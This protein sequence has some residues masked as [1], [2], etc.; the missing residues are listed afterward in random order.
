MEKKDLDQEVDYKEI[1]SKILTKDEFEKVNLIMNKKNKKKWPNPDK[2]LKR[3][4]RKELER[5]KDIVYFAHKGHI[6]KWSVSE[7]KVIGKIKSSLNDSF[8][9][10]YPNEYLIFTEIKL[11]PNLRDLFIGFGN[12]Y[13]EKI[14]FTKDD[15][16]HFI[17]NSL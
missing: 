12:G 6:M 15:S 17:Y 13:I 5:L 8:R 10:T 1:D 14:S 4:Q 3:A 9:E 7:G 11:S 16:N 2:K